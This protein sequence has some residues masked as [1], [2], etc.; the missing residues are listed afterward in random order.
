MSRIHS[1]NFSTILNGAINDSTTSVVITSATGFP[2]VG[3]GV[4]CN[5]SVQQGSDVEIMTVT[6]ITG[7]T[8]TVTR[9][10]E[11]TTPISFIDASIVEIRATAGSIDS[12]QDVIS[13]L[14]ISTATV[15]TG[16]KV[17]IQDVSDSD[18]IKTVTTQ[19]I[20]N[21]APAQ[22]ESTVT[23]TDITTN[24]SSTSKHGYLKKLSNSATE[25]MDGS[26][27]WST[28][29]GGGGG[30]GGL[31]LLSVATASSSSDLH[32]D[33]SLITSTYD[34]YLFVISDLKTSA[35]TPIYMTI[36]V[37][38]GSTDAGG[39]DWYSQA[40][41]Y[42]LGNGNTPA[43]HGAT[44]DGSFLLTAG[45]N[46]NNGGTDLTG[47]TV[48][49]HNPASASA[50]FEWKLSASYVGGY[51]NMVSGSGQNIA[52]Y[53]PPVNYIKFVP[54]SGNFVSG[55]IRLYGLQKV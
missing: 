34:S 54:T 27:N 32:F 18:N 22:A 44:R 52:G 15:A 10:S 7:T 16:D 9:G 49:M 28:P 4:T 39:S 33:S 23:F 17:L 11:G 6:A 20:A 48:W 47:G 13:G 21:L 5:I 24:N 55:T 31:V 35:T 14:S 45:Q 43:G 12:K 37:D 41:L 38:N 36:S 46:T 26:G 30:G 25:Y 19:A 50:Q 42:I 53:T 2:A 8:L 40:I 29:A 1:N 3:S 51:R